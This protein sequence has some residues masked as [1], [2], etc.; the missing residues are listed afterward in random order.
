G[1]QWEDISWDTGEIKVRR[2][3]G[4]RAWRHGC[5]DKNACSAA[6]PHLC[7]RRVGGGLVA[8]PLKTKTARRIVVVP[9][10]MIE[11]L[12]S[13]RRA[14]AAER[15]RAGELWTPQPGGGWVF[16]TEIGTPVD[17]RNDL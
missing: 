16:A 9:K 8:G 10:Q 15:L 14:Q 11:L 12:Q 7:P 1:L 5:S 2:A 13:H 4:R 3:L 6:R 17:P